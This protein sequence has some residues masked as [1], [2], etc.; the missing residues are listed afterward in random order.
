MSRTVR[1]D[2]YGPIGLHM[3]N[4]LISDLLQQTF[5]T[6]ARGKVRAVGCQISAMKP[7]RRVI[8]EVVAELEAGN[9]RLWNSAKDGQSLPRFRIQL[10]VETRCHRARLDDDVVI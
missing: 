10:I 2:G 9:R 5:Q 3:Q 8:R 6:E 7:F 1:Q 4:S